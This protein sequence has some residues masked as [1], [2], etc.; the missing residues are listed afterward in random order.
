VTR[1]LLDTQLLLWWLADDPRLP[2]EAIQ[3]IQDFEAEVFVSQAS[4]SEMAIKCS[5]GRL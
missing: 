3:R 4:L 2:A 1:L 5:L